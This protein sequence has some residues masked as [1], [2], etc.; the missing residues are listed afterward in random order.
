MISEA[1]ASSSASTARNV[2]MAFTGS[3]NIPASRGIT[4][5]SGRLTVEWAREAVDR[6]AGE[7][8][9]NAMAEDGVRGGYDLA[10]AR[11]GHGGRQRALDRQRRR[12]EAGAFP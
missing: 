7:I 1:S 8:V 3:S 2:P 10:H 6:G 9:L 11:D 4:R 5:D 12:G